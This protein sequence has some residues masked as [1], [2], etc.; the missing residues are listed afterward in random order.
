MTVVNNAKIIRRELLA[1]LCKLILNDTNLE[2]ANRIPIEMR[3]RKGNHV[4]C[5]V[6][7]D[8]AVVRYKILAMLGID[9]NT[10]DDELKLISSYLDEALE[11]G[12][13][14]TEAILTVVDE[15][16]SACQKNNYV[17][18]NMCQACVGRPCQVNC[19][20]NSISFHNNLAQIDT[21]TCVNCGLCEKV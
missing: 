3:P 19:P 21:N 17:V 7:R 9:G 14:N 16:C 18:T 15:A 8:R 1:R 6:H 10:E 11:N 2:Q 20:K 13:L 5:C 4:R 12:S